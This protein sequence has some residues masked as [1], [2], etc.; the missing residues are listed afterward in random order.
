MLE[1]N[2]EQDRVGLTYIYF[3]YND[4]HQT[5]VNLLGS[6]LQQLAMQSTALLAEIKSCY[7]RCT[8][9]KI[10]PTAEEIG[11]LLCLQVEKFNKVFMVFDALDECPEG[12]KTREKLLSRVRGL[13]PVANLMVTSRPLLSIESTFKNDLR[14]EIR[15]Q[16]QDVK[17]FIESQMDQEPNLIALLEGR[18][19]V[20]SSITTTIVG[21]IN[22]MF[23]IAVLHM[24]SLAKEDNIRDLKEC[25][26]RLPEDLDRT[27]DDAL[28][29]IKNLD[30]RRIARA[31]QVL[32]LINCAK[33]PL[34]LEEMQQALSIRE[35]DTFLDTDA[36]PGADSLISTCCGLV[37]VEDESQIV[38]LV[39]YTA[40]EYFARKAERYRNAEAHAFFAC[41]L[42]TYLSFT[43][44]EGWSLKDATYAEPENLGKD[45]ESNGLWHAT[46]LCMTKFLRD[47]VL[48]SYGAENLG[49]HA[50]EAF[51]KHE[52]ESSPC[53]TTTSLQ[54]SKSDKLWTLNKLM[55]DF[56]KKQD[57][58]A[59]LIEV[60]HHLIWTESPKIEWSYSK[61]AP[62]NVT[63]L[64]M[65]ATFGIQH[66]VEDYLS[67]GAKID[68][69]DSRGNTAL[70][71]A[72]QYGHVGVV[73][74]LLASGAIV[75]LQ[76]KCGRDALLW[77]IS[78]NRIAVARLLLQHGADSRACCDS[79][80]NEDSYDFAIMYGYEEMLE[81]LVE[82]E[83]DVSR[84]NE[85]M[86]IGLYRASEER[87][88]GVIR[89]L[90]RRAR[91]WN[92]STQHLTIAMAIA[93]GSGSFAVMKMLFEA[94][95]VV[96][97]SLLLVGDSPWETN[98]PLHEAVNHDH[99]DCVAWLLANGADANAR[100]TEGDSALV[101][102][103]REPFYKM[104]K[105]TRAI[106]HQLLE[107]GADPSM[108]DTKF[109]RPSLEWA[110]I[111]GDADIVRLLLQREE[112]SPD[113]RSLMLYL[114]NLYHSMEQRND[115][116]VD[117]LLCDEQVYELGTLSRLL[118][119]FIPADRGYERVVRKFLEFGASL[120][121]ED[122][123][124]MTALHLAAQEGHVAIVEL[125]LAKEANINS[126][127]PTEGVTP[128]MIAARAGN[129]DIVELL[130]RRGADID[131]FSEACFYGCSALA[132]A[133][134]QG[135]ITT[136]T[137]LLEKG[138][139]PNGQFRG[140]DHST[141]LHHV[142]RDCREYDDYNLPIGK[143]TSRQR[144]VFGLSRDLLRSSLD[145]LLKNG[146]DQEARDDE[147][148]TPLALAV[149][150]ENLEAAQLLLE[151]GANLESKDKFGC[152]PL[153]LAVRTGSLRAV[154]LLLDKGA[155]PYSLSPGRTRDYEDVSED[156]F[157]SAV[158][159]VLEAQS[160]TIGT[161]IEQTVQKLATRQ[162]TGP[163]LTFSPDRDT[164]SEILDRE[165]LH[166][167][168]STADRRNS[169]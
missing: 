94:G 138:A 110:V 125:L 25:L 132:Q 135:H 84:L 82:H 83:I 41:I 137:L 20:R 152:T 31:E 76:D 27:Y 2:C 106:V 43:Q 113:Q 162:E 46:E 16:E 30:S 8:R 124:G 160:K 3:V 57:G 28:E 23:L 74:M 1:R 142:A 85:K 22:G 51:A 166:T 78:Y 10:L 63:G 130:L 34:K 157:R 44:F 80:S 87:H 119:I 13:L 79:V 75:T 99:L 26:Q 15:A 115:E 116:Y 65:A 148:R 114:T 93:A 104:S 59:C 143:W 4:A 6:L 11:R 5:L 68:A 66:L 18:D 102:I 105:D 108:V 153:V 107:Y 86:R 70:H 81:I 134:G 149:R 141:L 54:N 35:G 122:P 100:G 165:N 50:R 147:D 112:C 38:R 62:T 40:E 117:Q 121:V 123:L 89:L 19:A 32:K 98:L 161:S 39:H 136:A 14:L 144:S 48:V 156:D 56:L 95:A 67:R 140:S 127:D 139:K 91:D 58:F 92:I 128:L 60:A 96:N 64:Q 167:E 133:I 129:T 164:A 37:V 61:Y 29:R 88:E 159:F 97:P 109:G 126:G 169:L 42:I 163:L 55:L 145:V 9:N 21:R 36:L 72:S 155:N 45:L 17:K 73:E 154:Q 168:E 150:W 90:L 52:Y 49:Y 24:N 47:N 69:E 120:K 77:A 53:F 101:E 71:K 151:R 131:A 118:L 33:R 7:E 111:A 158:K 103:C 12:D 146:A